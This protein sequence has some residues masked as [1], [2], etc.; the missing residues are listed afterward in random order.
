MAF[1]IIRPIILY[2][3]AQR[4]FDRLRERTERGYFRRESDPKLDAIC[5][6]IIDDYYERERAKRREGR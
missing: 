6:R 3:A 5:D 4:R 1:P 2:G